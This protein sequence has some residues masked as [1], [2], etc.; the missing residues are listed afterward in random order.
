ME[1]G[2][3]V[4][5]GINERGNRYGFVR[6]PAGEKLYFN[7]FGGYCTVVVGDEPRLANTWPDVLNPANPKV[8]SPFP[9]PGQ[10]LR[11]H[12]HPRR[13]NRPALRDAIAMWCLASLLESFAPSAP[14]P[15]PA[16]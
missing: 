16:A 9:V 15:Q 2:I 10:E 1:R 3:V 14:Q 13:A 8:R 7:Y 11:F 4:H 5:V 12:R 6:T